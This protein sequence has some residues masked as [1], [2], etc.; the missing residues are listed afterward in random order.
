MNQ[1]K[2]I[3]LL[4]NDEQFNKLHTTHVMVFGMGG[5][6]SFVC[7]ALI[8]SGIG[9]IS[10]VDHDDV[11]ITNL[12]RQL[13]ATHQ[14]LGTKKVESM[15]ERL[16]SINP[17]A[18]I[19]IYPI[20]YNE[21]SN[22]SLDGVDYVVDAI[23]SVPSKISLMAQCEKAGVPMIMACGTGNKMNPLDLRVSQLY[24][25]DMDP[26]AKKLRTLAKAR[27]LKSVKVVYSI[28][29][30]QVTLQEKGTYEKVIIGSMVFV[31]GSAGLLIASE[32]IKDVLKMV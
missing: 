16:L 25:T 17:E 8:R 5:V 11:E 19:N 32:V 7:E 18:K 13:I 27:G 12:N 23:D 22:I 2:R 29:A 26:L 15:K 28:E 14:T 20:F 24:K 9:Q 3:Q 6:G 30:P 1:F 31:P 21:D 10:L 4:L